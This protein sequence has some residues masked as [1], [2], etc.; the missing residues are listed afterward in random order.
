MESGLGG[1]SGARLVGAVDLVELSKRVGISESE[2]FAAIFQG[3]SQDDTDL[4]DHSVP[5]STPTRKSPPAPSSQW[6]GLA[7]NFSLD[8]RSS[9]RSIDL[10]V[11]EADET[12][13]PVSVALVTAAR[14]SG[15][16]EELRELQK[17]CGVS[18]LSHVLLGL[19][20]A[21]VEVAV[22]LLAA[23]SDA[24]RQAVEQEMANHAIDAHCRP[25]KIEFVDFG[26]DWSG[27]TADSILGARLSMAK[28]CG[29]AHFP[30]PFLLLPSDRIYDCAAIEFLMRYKV[31]SGARGQQGRML[32]LNALYR[33]PCTRSGW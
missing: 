6:S 33:T 22:V 31:R 15:G 2:L 11:E 16:E 18:V 26:A 24:V 17:V 5:P 25:M 12:P 28:Y 14:S 23:K 20:A 4:A 3:R 32:P 1:L 10:D 9:F 21:G 19:E 30:T 29:G 13:L 7:G 8:R 27:S